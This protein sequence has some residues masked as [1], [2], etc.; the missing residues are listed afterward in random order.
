M[1]V[2]SFQMIILLICWK[3][4][5]VSISI[6]LQNVDH[7]IFIANSFEI[8]AWQEIIRERVVGFSWC[9]D[10]IMIP[11]DPYGRN[12]RVLD[13]ILH[14]LKADTQTQIEDKQPQTK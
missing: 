4:V 10:F 5:P 2:Q 6:A 14:K 12:G 9:D 11:Q 7:S 1:T 13:L 3:Q 8:S